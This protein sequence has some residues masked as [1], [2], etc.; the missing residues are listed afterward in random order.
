M[1][2]LIKY[3]TRRG[4]YA[5]VHRC[6]ADSIEYANTTRGLAP[7]LFD[8]RAEALDVLA[9]IRER[10]EMRPHWRKRSR[11]TV[12]REDFKAPVPSG[13]ASRPR[14][15]VQATV[16]ESERY[17][18]ACDTVRALAA[19]NGVTLPAYVAEYLTAGRRT[20]YGGRASNG[21]YFISIDRWAFNETDRPGYLVQTVAHEYAH[22]AEVY[23][24]GRT[25]HG[26]QF[27]AY[28]RR[29]CPLEFQAYELCYKQV[30]ARAAGIR[31]SDAAPA[32]AAYVARQLDIKRARRQP[33]SVLWSRV[34]N[35]D[36]WS[37]GNE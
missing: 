11:Y 13:R 14:G 34:M 31:I 30:A 37:A 29:L 15:T 5:L 21:D 20:C 23:N 6:G 18:A 12:V 28:M 35:P 16:A 25:D 4:R 1:R 22:V 9:V 32:V 33:A 36:T 19:A 3:S 17:K 7:W 27:M 24:H 26:P 10:F 2:Y 8:T